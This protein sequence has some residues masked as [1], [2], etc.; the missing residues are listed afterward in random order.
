MYIGSYR[1]ALLHRAWKRNL[2]NTLH[3]VSLETRVT[4]LHA[5]MSASGRWCAVQ[6]PGT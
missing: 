5:E 2:P 1:V 3:V 6:L 4:V